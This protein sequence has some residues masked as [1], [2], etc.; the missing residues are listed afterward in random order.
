MN[1]HDVQMADRVDVLRDVAA[2]TTTRGGRAGED[3]RPLPGGSSVPCRV[4]TWQESGDAQASGRSAPE[5]VRRYRV[6]FAS[7]PPAALGRNHR[8][9][10]DAGPPLGVRTLSVVEPLTRDPH[11]RLWLVGVEDRG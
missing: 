5:D 3:W 9:S 7:P 4:T 2:G 8:L 10:W 6:C 11:G 1:P